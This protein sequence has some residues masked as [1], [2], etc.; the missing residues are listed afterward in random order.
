[1]RKAA[2]ALF[3]ALLAALWLPPGSGGEEREAAFRERLA[4]FRSW[5]AGKWAELGRFSESKGLYLFAEEDYARARRLGAKVK[6]YVPP[7]LPPPE[8]AKA[9]YDEWG[10]RR[11]AFLK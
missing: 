2:A 9:L 10:R 7:D 3:I 11:R 4:A 8:G 5:A 6:R 1:M